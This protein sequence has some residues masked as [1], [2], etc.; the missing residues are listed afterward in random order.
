MVSPHFQSKVSKHEVSCE[1]P[2]SALSWPHRVGQK[3]NAP[4]CQMIQVGYLPRSRRESL[5]GYLFSF[6]FPT[7]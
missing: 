4:Q 6:S 1:T 2:L 5:G 3:F 7:L